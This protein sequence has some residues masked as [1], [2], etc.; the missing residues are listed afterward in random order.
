LEKVHVKP[1]AK[2]NTPRAARR[3][4]PTMNQFSCTNPRNRYGAN[5]ITKYKTRKDGSNPI[6]TKTKDVELRGDII[7]YIAKQNSRAN[8]TPS[9]EYI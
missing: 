5:S 7:K 8:K 4:A 1:I 6:A 2:A 9:T 3:G